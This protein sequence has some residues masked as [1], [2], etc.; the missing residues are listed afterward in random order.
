MSAALPL[1]SNKQARQIFMARQGLCKSP[2]KNM[3]KDAL[4]S[5]IVQ[6]GFVQVDSIRTVERAH[7]MI[8]FARDQNYHPEQLRQLLEEDRRLFEHWTH[9]A[10][11]VPTE[12]YSHWRGRFARAELHLRNRWRDV[13]PRGQVKGKTV[14]FE[15]ILDEVRVHVFE[16][17]PTLSRD[18]KVWSGPKQTKKNGW[19]QWHPGKT[20]LEYLWRTGE[21]LISHRNGFQKAFDLHDRVIR[22]E[23]QNVPV[24]SGETFIDWACSNALDRLGFAT[25]GELAAY[26]GS[27]NSTEARTWCARNNGKEII[28]VLVEDAGGVRPN[29]AFARPALLDQL[30]DLPNPPNK[31]RI[32]SPFDPLIRDRKRLKRLFDFEYRIEIFIPEAKRKFGYY[33]FPLLE[34]DR[35]IGRIDMQARRDDDVLCVTGLWLEPKFKLTKSRQ[36]NLKTELNRQANF[37]GMGRVAWELEPKKR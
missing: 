17:G 35:L 15:D 26:W 20:A 25:S 6:L 36:A 34:K 18:L 29:R 32:L 2:K 16:N 37:I 3:G 9:D 10:S 31:V 28:E 33:V 11:I 30:S 22:D 1:I 13:R 21:L 8:L 5:L 23:I 7:H 4:H 19:W 27:V 12:F 24:Q 14:T